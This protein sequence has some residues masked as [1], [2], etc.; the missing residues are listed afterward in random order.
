MTTSQTRKLT[1]WIRTRINGAGPVR[2]KAMPLPSTANVVTSSSGA[3]A[4]NTRWGG[5]FAPIA[6]IAG[7]VAEEPPAGA[8]RLGGHRA[9]QQHTHEE[10]HRQQ[11]AQRDHGDD[12]DREQHQQDRAQWDT[13][14]AVAGAEV[15]QP[16]VVDQYDAARDRAAF[17]RA[18]VEQ[19]AGDRGPRADRQG[20]GPVRSSRRRTA[21]GASCSARPGRC[22][23]R[24]GRPR[25][26][27]SADSSRWYP[28]A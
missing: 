23:R 9:D 15:G 20:G 12:L 8:G 21:T 19:A 25:P 4:R 1:A 16:V 18:Q 11:A 3:N 24:Q 7:V 17:D 13:V 5:P 6:G 27:P 22:P 14:L 28:E 2:D 26:V 10:V